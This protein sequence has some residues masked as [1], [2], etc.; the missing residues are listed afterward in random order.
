MA[1]DL[2]SAGFKRPRKADSLVQ[3][4]ERNDEAVGNR[5]K[6]LTNW[7]K[8]FNSQKHVH[9][10]VYEKSLLGCSTKTFTM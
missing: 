4:Q 8:M 7:R 10:R 2:E 5:F 3:T 9:L 1:E 6:S